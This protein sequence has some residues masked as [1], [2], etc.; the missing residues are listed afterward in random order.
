MRSALVLLHLSLWITV[1]HAFFPWFPNY[2]CDEGDDCKAEKR[3]Q[4]DGTAQDVV[5]AIRVSG[6]LKPSTFPIGQRRGF[7]S[8]PVAR[9][10]S[11]LLRKYSRYQPTPLADESTA[12]A[13]R[14]NVYRVIEP[15]KTDQKYGAGIWQDG[16]DFSYFVQAKLGS[17]GKELYMLVDTGAGTSW[18]MGSD[19]ASPACGLHNSFGPDDSKTFERVDEHYSVKYGSGSVKGSKVT[20]T[21]NVAGMNLKFKFGVANETSDDF[22]HFPFDGILG[23]SLSGG[24][25]DNFM[26]IVADSKTLDK[27]VFCV[28]INRAAD[29][30]NTGEL[31][32]GACNNDKYTGDFTYTDVGSSNGDW[33][34]PMDGLTYD[35]KK[36]GVKG[37]LAY[38]DTG[39]SYVFGPESDVKAFH[40]NIPGSSSSDGTTW[41]VPCDS[42]EEVTYI[43]S[44]VSYTI[45]AKDWRSKPKDG[46]CTSN[47]YGHE[48]VP[49]S[50]LLGDLFLKNVYAVFDADEKRIG[51]ANRAP[52]PGAESE[53]SNADETTKQASPTAK[54]TTSAQASTANPSPRPTLSEQQ[55]QGSPSAEPAVPDSQPTTAST[56]VTQPE[57][58]IPTG[59]SSEGQDDQQT[60]GTSGADAAQTN[61]PSSGAQLRSHGVVSAVF[62]MAAMAAIY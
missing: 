33:A 53:D 61:E 48:V 43:F 35:G 19:C 11:R 24:E 46:V 49:N 57:P 10:V 26:N 38:I 45:S 28:F 1:S 29:G 30:P 55:G 15:E 58:S 8:E 62:A 20:D 39:T 25:S 52:V 27:N 59:Q 3:A 13:K 56:G 44:G 42:N 37:K 14:Q 22:N 60:T 32:F 6:A 5:N 36:A 17:E 23:L 18:V 54:T 40:E 50:W 4:L 21:I 47:I 9:I 7:E 34:V 2:R 16:S 51:F 31:S 12:L 41:T